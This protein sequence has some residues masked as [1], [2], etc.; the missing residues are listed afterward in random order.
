MQ[1]AEACVVK[2]TR[3][4]LCIG[5]I[6]AGKSTLCAALSTQINL[7][8]FSIDECRRTYSDETPAGEANAWSQFLR[9]SQETMDGIFECSGGGPFVHLLRLALKSAHA[10]LLVVYVLTPAE[11]CRQRVHQRPVTVPYPDFGISLEATIPHVERE[12]EKMIQTVW[13][14]ERIIEVDGLAPMATQ[15]AAVK[16][17]IGNTCYECAR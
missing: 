4:I 7:P 15:L 17:A 12:L 8:F 5:N 13:S 1:H 11:A 16:R 14:R 10:D 3:R 2:G 9:L 6:A